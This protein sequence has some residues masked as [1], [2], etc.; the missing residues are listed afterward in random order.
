M[1]NLQSFLYSYNKVLFCLIQND[2]LNRFMAP[3]H[4]EF[5]ETILSTRVK[6]YFS[7][8]KQRKKILH[9]S[10][11]AVDVSIIWTW[12]TILHSLSLRLIVC[13]C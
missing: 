10:V 13:F 4:K 1:P 8:C 7:F 11:T 5:K 2:H 6:I 12:R 9:D 3:Q